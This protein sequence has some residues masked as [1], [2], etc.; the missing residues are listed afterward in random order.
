MGQAEFFRKIRTAASLPPRDKAW[1]AMLYPMSGLV[2]AA[3]LLLPF[4]RLARFLG[5]PHGNIQLTPLATPD[6]VR[7]AARIG[8]ACALVARYTPWQ[9]LCLVQAVMAKTLLDHYRIPYALYLGVSKPGA[10]AG[11]Q[12]E[13]PGLKAHAWV[14]VGPRVIAGRDGHRA[15]TVV[16]TFV[17]PAILNPC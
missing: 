15:F 5:V 14:A 9:S 17:S 10:R 12:G 16:S 8:A 11:T 2:R 3:L 6:Q 1:F 4:R 13:V 7:L